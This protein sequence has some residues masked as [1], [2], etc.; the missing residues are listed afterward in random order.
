MADEQPHSARFED[1]P[2]HR[3]LGLRLIEHGDGHARICLDTGSV[4]LGGVGGSVHGGVLAAI[5]DIVMLQAIMTIDMDGKQ[6][7]GTADLGITYLRPALGKQIF[8][9][10]T[11]VKNGRQLALI[12]IDITDEKGNLCARGR[13]LYA[14][15]PIEGRG[16]WGSGAPDQR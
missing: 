3:A 5:V 6:P 16:A 14:F 13:T 7:A 9:D 12:E 11:V 2:L 4:T 15:R 8:A 10:A 1:H